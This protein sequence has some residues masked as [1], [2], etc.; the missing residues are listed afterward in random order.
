MTI[1]MVRAII[2]GRI[3]N[4]LLTGSWIMEDKDFTNEGLCRLDIGLANELHYVIT[5]PPT[6][7]NE[8]QI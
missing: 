1:E 4:I 8:I 3:S 5:M 7:M 6:V 2:C